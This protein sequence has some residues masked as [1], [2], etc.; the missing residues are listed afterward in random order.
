MLAFRCWKTMVIRLPGT[1]GVLALFKAEQTG[2]IL[3]LHRPTNGA[4]IKKQLGA[5]AT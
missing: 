5:G 1:G 2:L 4:E 3:T